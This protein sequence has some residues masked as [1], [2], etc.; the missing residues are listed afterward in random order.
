MPRLDPGVAEVR[1]ACGDVESAGSSYDAEVDQRILRGACLRE[2][3]YRLEDES[4]AIQEVGHQWTQGGEATF[5]VCFSVRGAMYCEGLA[6]E[7]HDE[8]SAVREVRVEI[9]C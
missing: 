4:R 6:G 9:E 7:S 3:S 5:G 2:A 8:D 1:I